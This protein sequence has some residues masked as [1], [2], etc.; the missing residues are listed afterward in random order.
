MNPQ[1]VGAMKPTVQSSEDAC[2][3]CQQDE[4]CA[5]FG[6]TGRVCKRSARISYKLEHA[7]GEQDREAFL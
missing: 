7:S 1:A 5:R 3:W 4:A 2:P 6:V